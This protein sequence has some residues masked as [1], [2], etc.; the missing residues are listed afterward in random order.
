MN[1]LKT[2]NSLGQSIWLD[3]IRRSWLQNGTFAKLI[4]D[5]GLSGVTSNPAIFA[6]PITE[7][8]DYDG[9]IPTLSAEG[10]DASPAYERLMVADVQAAA[11]LLRPVFDR[12]GG[13]D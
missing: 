5:D 3:D 6:Q 10:L 8:K 4:S 12:T 11:D 7:S 9:A 2:V 13:A 1:T